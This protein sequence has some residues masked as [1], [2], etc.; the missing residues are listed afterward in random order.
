VSQ[1]AAIA[2]GHGADLVDAV[3]PDP[4]LH[5]SGLSS[6]S[7]LDSGRKRLPGR[8][9]IEGP[10]CAPVLCGIVAWIQDRRRQAI[11]TGP[12]RK[13]LSDVNLPI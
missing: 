1:P 8:A 6:R 9:P 11:P 13:G 5:G 3:V 7:G 10:A 12:S 2:Q 4:V